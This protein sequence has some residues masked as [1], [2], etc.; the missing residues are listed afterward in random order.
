[1]KVKYVPAFQEHELQFVVSRSQKTSDGPVATL[2]D[3]EIEE[4]R[5]TVLERGKHARYGEYSSPPDYTD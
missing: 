2:S 5:L 3:D 1:V 4:N